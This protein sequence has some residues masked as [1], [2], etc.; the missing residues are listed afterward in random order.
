MNSEE[1]VS[2]IILYVKYAAAEAT[3][4]NLNDPPGRL[5]LADERSRSDW[6]KSLPEDDMAHVNSI[7]LTSIH[8]AVFGLLA[9]LDGARVIDSCGGHFEL[10][11]LGPDGR[12]LLNDPN[13]IALHDL[14]NANSSLSEG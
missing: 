4:D 9:V 2:A 6:Y 8:E 3:I 11:H 12:V 14:M 7:I 10:S 13:A 1:F 5:V